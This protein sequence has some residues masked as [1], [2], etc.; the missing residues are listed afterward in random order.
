MFQFIVVA[1]CERLPICTLTG[2]EILV[3]LAGRTRV[4]AML[5]NAESA[6][7]VGNPAVAVSPTTLLA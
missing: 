4:L 2:A 1:F 6:D 7:V 3:P 5:E